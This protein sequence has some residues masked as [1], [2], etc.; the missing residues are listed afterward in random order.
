MQA[1]SAQPTRFKRDIHLVDSTGFRSIR[2]VGREKAMA[3]V[4]AGE[5]AIN[6]TSRGGAVVEVKLLAESQPAERNPQDVRIASQPGLKTS[7]ASAVSRGEA[8]NYER[9]KNATGSH[10]SSE[11]GLVLARYGNKCLRCEAPGEAVTLTKD[12]IVPLAS[13]G[14]DYASNLQPLCLSCNC[15]KGNRE[16]DFRGSLAYAAA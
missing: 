8:A 14:T 16:I 9:R 13:G 3:M 10:T 7:I 1:T 4:A 15:W 6:D 11:W 5:A 12:H 2:Y